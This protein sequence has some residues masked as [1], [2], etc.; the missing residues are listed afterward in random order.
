MHDDAA[1]VVGGAAAVE[2]AV[3]LGGLERPARPGLLRAGRL[4]VVVR[5][6]QDGGSARLRRALAEHRLRRARHVHHAHVRQ[7]GLGQQSRHR[8][9][10]L[11]H[12][13]GGE[14]RERDRRQPHELPEVVDEPR[15]EVLDGRLQVCGH[16][17]LLLIGPHF[18]ASGWGSM[19]P[20]RSTTRRTCRCTPR[21]VGRTFRGTRPV[22]M[23]LPRP[24]RRPPPGGA[25]RFCRRI[26]QS[27]VSWSSNPSTNSR[28]PSSLSGAYTETKISA[29]CTN[30]GSRITGRLA[31]PAVPSCQRVLRS[32]QCRVRV[33]GVRTAVRAEQPQYRLLARSLEPRRVQL[34]D[35]LTGLRLRRGRLLL[36]SPQRHAGDHQRDD[37]DDDRDVDPLV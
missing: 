1:L 2:P 21:A 20:P 37:R 17:A 33:L 13:R 6:E 10:A 14:V 12:R 23:H 16:G 15:H 32:G 31:G 27:M 35:E 4:H 3:A 28:N 18:A 34:G 11:L 25:R 36:L 29:A 19:P 8:R 30:C 7:A 5:V 9:A 22:L 24:Q 26:G